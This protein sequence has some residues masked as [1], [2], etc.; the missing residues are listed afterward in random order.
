MFIEKRVSEPT[1]DTALLH[2][3]IPTEVMTE[4]GATPV[5]DYATRVLVEIPDGQ[6]E[7][8]AE[9]AGALGYVTYERPAFDRIRLNGYDFASTGGRPDLPAELQI[10]DYEGEVGLY[11]TQMVG[12]PKPGWI[13]D[14]RERAD[15]VR[16]FAENTFLVRARPGTMGNLWNHPEIQYV[17]VHQPAFKLHRALRNA[18]GSVKTIIQIDRGQEL[19]SFEQ[20]MSRLL[21]RQFR[22]PGGTGESLMA[23]LSVEAIAV[24]VARPEVLWI[25]P[26]AAPA[27]SDER[28]AM[29]MD[30]QITGPRPKPLPRPSN[31]SDAAAASP[32]TDARAWR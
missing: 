29:V 9:N 24:L 11:L 7:A 18:E 17:G 25:E 16:Y 8:F 23:T 20:E 22:V 10:E 12:P 32:P 27:P 6:F 14:L 1:A 21:D 2:E 26:Y 30:S 13:S 3:P 19:E 31:A 15:I 5:A 28:H 4:L